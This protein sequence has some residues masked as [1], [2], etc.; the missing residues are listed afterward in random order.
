M[1]A[2]VPEPCILCRWA[3]STAADSEHSMWYVEWFR[4]ME[5]QGKDIVEEERLIDAMLGDLPATVFLQLGVHEQPLEPTV[6]LT[7]FL[8]FLPR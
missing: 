7:Q 5:A 4:A 2:R 3:E 1:N 8:E 6:L